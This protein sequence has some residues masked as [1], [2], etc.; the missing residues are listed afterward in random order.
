MEMSCPDPN[1]RIPTATKSLGCS[2][3]AEA[4][5][6]THAA[7][8]DLCLQC[9]NSERLHHGLGWLGLHFHLLAARSWPN[10]TLVPALVAGFTR[11][12]IL[13]RPGIVK[14]PFFFTSVVARVAKLPRSPD[15]A[16]VLSS[17][18][19]ESCLMR[20]PF[21]MALP[22][23]AEAFIAFIVFIGAMVERMSDNRP[24]DRNHNCT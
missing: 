1:R 20:L 8:S 17:C 12:L 4:E 24:A 10:I 9:C 3:H 11:V 18:C 15:T 22:A 2:C 19:S 16:F 5:C 6:P 21:V 7:L 23:F 14:M 13:Q